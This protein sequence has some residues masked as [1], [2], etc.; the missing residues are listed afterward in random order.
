M[1]Y[2]IQHCVDTEGNLQN[3]ECRNSLYVCLSFSLSLFFLVLFIFSQRKKMI[4][5]W[6][7]GQTIFQE[8]VCLSH[9]LFFL[10]FEQ[11]RDERACKTKHKKNR[12]MKKKP[13]QVEVQACFHLNISVRVR[14][15]E[16][17]SESRKF[18]VEK[19]MH[20]TNSLHKSNRERYNNLKKE[21]L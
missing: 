12:E 1:I 6:I 5:I 9:M 20:K 15:R 4:N 13:P 2:I 10:F 3:K 11:K 8:I 17:V 14:G 21:N 16:K 7:P 19:K 18:Q